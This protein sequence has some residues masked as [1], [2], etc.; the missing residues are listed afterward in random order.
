MTNFSI[1]FMDATTIILIIILVLQLL[2]PLFIYLGK[3]WIDNKIKLEFNKKLALFNNDLLIKQR[4]ELIAELVSEWISFPDDT[5][6]LNELTFQA[7][8]W[9]PKNIALDLSNTLSHKADAKNIKD[10]IS[11]VRVH[12]LGENERVSPN[13]IVDF[14]GIRFKPTIKKF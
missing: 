11:D 9:L 8:L 7:F 1:S 4:S 12:L 10:I 14:T 3:L 13:E 2:T 5:K 6:K